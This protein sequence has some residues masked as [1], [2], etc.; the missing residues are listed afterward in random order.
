M[1]ASD[2]E[3]RP[4]NG[5]ANIQLGNT[6][7]EVRA[8]LATNGHPYDFMEDGWEID[9]HAPETT[10]YFDDSSP[11]RL[12]QI[13]FY[14]KD[15]RVA[16]QPVIGLTLAEALLPFN[17]QSFDD[18]LWSMVSIEEEFPNGMP[19]SDSMRPRRASAKEKLDSGTVWIKSQGIG[20]V[21]M[22]GLVHAIAMRQ[23]GGEPKVGCGQLDSESM[24]LALAIKPE[25]ASKRKPAET[26]HFPGIEPQTSP[27]ASAPSSQTAKRS[28][29]S[30]KNPSV[31][32]RTVFS[33][34][35]I[36]FLAMPAGIVYH[37][38]TAWKNSKDVVG[39]V[40]STKPEG[41]FPDEIIVEYSIP[42][43]GKHSVTIPSTYTTAREIGQEVELLYLDEQ[44]ER[45]MTRIQIRDEGWSVSPYLLFGSVGLATFFLHLAFPNHIRFKSS[46]RSR[47]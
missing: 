14:D 43:S 30:Y 7:A 18:S 37:D 12:V 2:I 44:P 26:Y 10:F 11:Q 3:I 42:E 34:L 46:S 8:A 19:V 24:T 25:A 41:P 31:L 5:W 38:I 35:T 47:L 36:L 1:Y 21:M 6:I 45:A 39:R 28:T 27:K 13:V 16:D 9:I 15:H 17:V 4:G 20:L 33:L 22:F 23:M 29:S 40:V 32:R